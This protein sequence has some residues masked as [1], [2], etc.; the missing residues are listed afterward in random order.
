MK[1]HM[2]RFQSSGDTTMDQERDASLWLDSGLEVTAPFKDHVSRVLETQGHISATQ[3]RYQQ[4]S[5][6]V[7]ILNKVY[8]PDA[9][10]AAKGSRYCAGGFQ[11][12]VKNSTAYKTVLLE[13][14]RCALEEDC[15]R[16][17]GSEVVLINYIDYSFLRCF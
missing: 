9:Y 2:I 12:F 16:N 1:E 15:I 3:A 6:S 5:E 8:G 4:S 10:E 11:G 14:A 17:V 13:A 7:Q